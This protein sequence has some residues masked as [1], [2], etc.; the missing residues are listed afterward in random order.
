MRIKL[1]ALFKHLC[2]C[3]SYWRRCL[4]IGHTQKLSQN[5]KTEVAVFIVADTRHR[6]LKQQVGI[7]RFIH[8]SIRWCKTVLKLAL[9]HIS[10]GWWR[11][12]CRYMQI[13]E[14]LQNF[15]DGLSYLLTFR[16][17]LQAL[18]RSV[19]GKTRSFAV[20]YRKLPLNT[21]D[22]RSPSKPDILDTH[23]VHRCRDLAQYIMGGD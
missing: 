18:N 20:K 3:K 8:V 17:I 11:H 10:T 6:V 1:D 7:H 22:K 4:Y 12:V 23:C 13:C 14:V 5:R 15:N 9:K 2:V 16:M 21:F 19:K